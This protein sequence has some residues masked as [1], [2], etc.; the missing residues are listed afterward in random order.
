MKIVALAD[1]HIPKK[2][3]QLPNW[4]I[5]ELKTTDLILHAGDWSSMD[6]YYELCQYAPVEGVY[7]NIEEKEVKDYFHLNNL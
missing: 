4:L 3:K 6:I 5:G 1:T 7:G 2:S